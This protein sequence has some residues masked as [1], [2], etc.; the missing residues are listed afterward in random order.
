MTHENYGSALQTYALKT[1]L[2][3]KGYNVEVINYV[4]DAKKDLLHITYRKLKKIYKG[5]NNSYNR[6]TY[7]FLNFRKRYLNETKLYTS[8]NE[9]E[10]CNYDI[11]ICGSDQIWSASRFDE[12]Y[13]LNF[14]DNKLIIE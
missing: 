7:L 11:Y 12:S 8:S 14:V 2:E 13:F 9:L 10:M 4:K 6:R 3:E 5:K 1:V